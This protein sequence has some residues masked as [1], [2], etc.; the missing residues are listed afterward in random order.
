[1]GDIDIVREEQVAV[2][3]KGKSQVFRN[4]VWVWEIPSQKL[5]EVI[6]LSVRRQ[7]DTV[8]NYAQFVARRLQDFGII[9]EVESTI[10]PIYDG[11][12]LV[13]AFKIRGVRK[14]IIEKKLR[15]LKRHSKDWMTT[16]MKYKRLE[17]L[18]DRVVSSERA[19]RDRTSRTSSEE[20][21]EEG[22][23]AEGE[24]KRLNNTGV[25]EGDRGEVS[26]VD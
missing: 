13:L 18:I 17:K 23:G 10:S 5:L 3:R 21:E 22:G 25:S 19:I 24:R 11:Y 14:D 12:K 9:I 4:V 6:G 1:M 2:D 7:L 16:S 20:A 26:H 8:E 15:I